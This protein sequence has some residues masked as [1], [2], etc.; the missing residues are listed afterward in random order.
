MVTKKQINKESALLEVRNLQTYFYTADGVVKAVDGVD[1]NVYPKKTLG[2][3]GESGCGKSITTKSI[4]RLIDN[5]GKIINGSMNLYDSNHENPQDIA[6]LNIDALKKVRGGKISMIFQEPMTSFS[7][8]HTIG[9]QITE[10]ITLHLDYTKKE[11]MELA[12]DWLIRVGMNNPKQRLGQYAFEL[13]GGQRQRAMIAMALCTNPDILIADEPTTALDV[14]TQA[15]TLDLLNE[16]QEKN[17][18]SIIMITHDLGV[19]AELA[20]DVNVMYLGKVVESGTIEQVYKDPLHPYTKSL[21]SSIPSM[22]TKHRERLP[23]LQGTIPHP[24]AR[25]SGCNFQPN[26]DGEKKE[27]LDASPISIEESPGHFVLY[28]GVCYEQDKCAW[29]PRGI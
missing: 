23:I 20:D 27:C 15:Q 22:A 8:I 19:I 17:G 4:L 7:P 24:V 9:N 21:L 18:M 11:A 29:Y 3:V 26:C 28:C 14:T 10:A 25:P 12:E 1:I 2:I 16:L 6:T 13:S 5:P